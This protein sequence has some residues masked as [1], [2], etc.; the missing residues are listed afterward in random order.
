MV[1]ADD[2]MRPYTL[3]ED[4]P[5][6]LGADEICRGKLLKAGAN[7][8]TRRS[9][10]VLRA[11]LDVLGKTVRE[12]PDNYERGELLVDSATD[13]ETNASLELARENCLLLRRGPLADG[14]TVKMAQTGR[15]ATWGST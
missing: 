3:M 7:G 13:L 12:A 8:Y 10:D 14:A 11:F 4:S 9:F 1:S 5:E 2:D 15:S 6:S